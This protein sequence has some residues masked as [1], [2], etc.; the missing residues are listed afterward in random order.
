MQQSACFSYSVITVSFQEWEWSQDTKTELY[1][2][3][4][5]LVSGSVVLRQAKE[6]RLK[7]LHAPESQC[8]IPG[9]ARVQVVVGNHHSL[10]PCGQ[11]CLYAVGSVFKHQALSKDEREENWA[12]LSYKPISSTGF[13]PCRLC[14]AEAKN[15]H[16]NM[17]ISISKV[18]KLTLLRGVLFTSARWNIHLVYDL[19]KGAF[20]GFV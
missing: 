19:E 13:Y 15:K 11:R 18:M 4:L 14:R 9:K 7:L 6:L 5:G 10:H 12:I 20:I 1:G 3:V 2:V 16:G 17:S 8:G